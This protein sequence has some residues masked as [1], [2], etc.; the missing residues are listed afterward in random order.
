[1][2]HSSTQEVKEEVL[3]SAFLSPIGIIMMGVAVFAD[4]SEALI[5]LIPI[6]GP[7]LSVIIDIG[8]LLIIGGW[9]YLRSG[10]I[11]APRKTAAR[12]GKAAKWAKRLKWLRPLCIIIEMIPVI[13]SAPAWTIAVYLELKYG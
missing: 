8:A 12:I 9:M 3:G 7:I 1:M 2:P 5:E 6:V 11:R 10:V 4:V 13:G